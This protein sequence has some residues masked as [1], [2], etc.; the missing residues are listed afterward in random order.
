MKSTQPFSISKAIHFGFQTTL[1]NFLLMLGVMATGGIINVIR[2]GA[3]PGIFLLMSFFL[4]HASYPSLPHT[5]LSLGSFKVLLS[6]LVIFVIFK[7]IDSVVS[8]GFT[9]IT[10]LL[11]DNKPTHY[12]DLFSC[13]HLA[14]KH[15]TASAL[16]VLIVVC[17]L[18]LFIVPGIL[19]MVM[20]GFFSYAIVDKELG[21][22]DAL[23]ESYRITNNSKSL[24]V[25]LFI[26]LI[27]LNALGGA[28]CGL[29]LLITYPMTALACAYVYRALQAQQ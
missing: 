28:C 26:I 12:S 20:F 17:G 3:I 7:L 11:H 5:I 21:P 9:K 29:G 23:K 13:A 22:I 25:S 27:A 8:L 10:L 6:A 1:D 14:L 16:Y 24:L 4:Y 15:F 2:F 18:M 19:F